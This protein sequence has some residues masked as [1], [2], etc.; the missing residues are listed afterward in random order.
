MDVQ[1]SENRHL[2]AFLAAL[3]ALLTTFFEHTPTLREP[4]GV[5]AFGAAL[6]FEVGVHQVCSAGMFL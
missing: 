6:L 5:L 4:Q 2:H 1:T 3:G